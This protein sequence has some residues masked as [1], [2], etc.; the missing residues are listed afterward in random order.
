MLTRHSKHATADQPGTSTRPRMLMVVIS[1][2][3]LENCEFDHREWPDGAADAF[4]RAAGMIRGGRQATESG[5]DGD[6]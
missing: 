2:M 1:G 3:I 6:R 5:K 4:E